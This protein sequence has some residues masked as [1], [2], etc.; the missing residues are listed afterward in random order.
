MLH[1][2][3]QGCQVDIRIIL[4]VITK[5]LLRILLSYH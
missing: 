5:V 3:E 4:N 1:S 2:D